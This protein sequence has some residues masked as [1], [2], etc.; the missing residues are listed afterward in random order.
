MEN[1]K[2]TEKRTTM[3]K[4]RWL[5]ERRIDKKEIDFKNK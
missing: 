5:C 4:W 1:I 3:D 2:N